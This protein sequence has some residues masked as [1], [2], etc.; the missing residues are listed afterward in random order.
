MT[1]DGLAEFLANY[2]FTVAALFAA[3]PLFALLLGAVHG[4]GNGGGLPWK[5]VY[6][7]LL[8][9]AC[10]PGIFAAMLTAYRLLFLNTDLTKVNVLIYFLP[11]VSMLAT[12]VLVKR[13]VGEFAR[14]PGFGRLAGLMLM[15]GLS[16]GVAFVLHRMHFFIGFLGDLGSLLLYATAAFALLQ[17][18]RNKLFGAKDDRALKDVVAGEKADA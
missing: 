4:K 12:L 9:M 8:Y 14:V 3:P 17:W 16:F 6:T 10:V 15:L 1:I 13:N 7:L 11:I 2:P 18:A 5:Y